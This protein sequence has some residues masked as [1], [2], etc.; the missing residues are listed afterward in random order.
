MV[1]EPCPECGM[2][3]LE[4]CEILTD[5]TPVGSKGFQAV[6]HKDLPQGDRPCGYTGPFNDPDGAKHNKLSLMVALGTLVYEGKIVFCQSP[7]SH[8][9]GKPSWFW[10][11]Q[12]GR[13]NEKYFETFDDAIRD[14][15]RHYK[16][17]LAGSK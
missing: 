2:D 14:A 9:K 5:E 4:V 10:R 17:P 3:T 6:C 15:H 16:V 13:S 1:L 7:D 11:S 12:D 8:K